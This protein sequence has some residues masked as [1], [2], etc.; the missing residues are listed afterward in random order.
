MHKKILYITFMFSILCCSSKDVYAQATANDAAALHYKIYQ[1]A[2]SLNDF[3]TAIQS[4]HYLVAMDSVKYGNYEDTLAIL[5][6]Q[7]NAFSPA[8][9]LANRLLTQKGYSEIR[10][11]IKG[12]AAKNMSLPIEAI[13]AFNELFNRTNNPAYGMELLQME[14]GIRRIGE[15]IVTG[16]KVLNAL[17]LNDS[18]QVNM[19]R[20]QNQSIQSVSMRAAVHNILGLAYLDL[21]DKKSAVSHFEEALKYTPDF[22]QAKNN[23]AV[24]NAMVSNTGKQK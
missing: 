15:S 19:P 18:S 16:N 8:Y 13:N 2:L 3:G 1:Q 12:I 9:I 23:L 14:Y 7:I 10:L 4:L 11:Q 24:A 6:T 5:Y 21:Q 20:L 17:P 22:E